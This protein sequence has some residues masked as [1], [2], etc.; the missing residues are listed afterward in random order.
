VTTL[1]ADDLPSALR[2]NVIDLI[3]AKRKRDE[4]QAA[5]D[6][7]A[8]YALTFEL[9]QDQVRRCSD[10]VADLINTGASPAR[11]IGIAKQ[12]VRWLVRQLNQWFPGGAA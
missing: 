9:P 2:S 5:R 3:A 10:M 11:A 4:I 6:S 7:V 8:S 12:H 1:C